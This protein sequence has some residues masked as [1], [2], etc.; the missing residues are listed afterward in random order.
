MKLL[1][2]LSALPA[3]LLLKGCTTCTTCTTSPSRPSAS[4][5]SGPPTC[6]QQEGGWTNPSDLNLN[7][8]TA[9]GITNEL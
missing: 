6:K 7:G 4:E 2:L 3:M 5:R 8:T 1:L 9:L